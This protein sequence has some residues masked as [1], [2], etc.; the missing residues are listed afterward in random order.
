MAERVRLALTITCTCGHAER[1]Q[2]GPVWRCPQCGSEWDTGQVP[3]EEYRAY[4]RAVRRVRLLSLLGVVV[5]A[6]VTALLALLVSPALLPVGIV[7][8]GVWY[9]WYLPSH[10]KQVRRLYET[11]PRW[12]ITANTTNPESKG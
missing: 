10:R 12:E 4:G 6:A 3:A 9:F 2:P 11:L 5:C 1:V 8:L 7:L